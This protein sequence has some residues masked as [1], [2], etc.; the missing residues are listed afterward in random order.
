MDDV[1]EDPSRCHH[2]SAPRR[3][4]RDPWVEPK[5][6]V[7]PLAGDTSSAPVHPPTLAPATLQRVRRLGRNLERFADGEIAA[8]ISR[9]LPVEIGIVRR[10]IV[11]AVGGVR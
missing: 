7:T 10:L 9:L 8:D 11:G 6:V 5:I 3:L 2:P 1:L 4:P